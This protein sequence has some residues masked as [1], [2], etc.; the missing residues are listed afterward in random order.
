MR[1]LS[2]AELTSFP[3]PD[4][5]VLSGSLDHNAILWNIETAEA[6]HKFRHAKSV[7][8]VQLKPSH[9]RLAT[10]SSDGN[11]KLW[12]MNTHSVV[13]TF[14]S[15][16]AYTC[17]QYF[18]DYNTLILGDAGGSIYFWDTRSSQ[19]PTFVHTEHKEYSVFG[20]HYE[21][22]EGKLVSSAKDNRLIYYNIR[23]NRGM[24]QIKEYAPM[25]SV[26]NNLLLTGSPASG[27]VK[28]W[29]LYSDKPSSVIPTGTTMTSF[30][31]D[32]SCMRVGFD[33]KIKTWTFH[34]D[35]FDP[36]FKKERLLAEIK[37]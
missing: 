8:A 34:D 16:N 1:R 35:S 21:P 26:K 6:V 27:T 13:S 9:A 7:V 15:K 19:K 29:E 24:K 11:C 14:E 18:P 2:F 37:S 32:D 20:L 31:F 10:A 17:M 36:S 30:D 22:G 25:L 12:D 33:K 4:S 5:Y 28:V 3:S 23:R